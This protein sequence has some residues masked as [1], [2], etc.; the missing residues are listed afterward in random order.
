VI[1]GA[2]L[3]RFLFSSGGV[4]AVIAAVLLSVFLRPRSRLARIS[5]VVVV[6]LYVVASSYPI[7][8]AVAVRLAQPF[9]PLTLEQAPPG[10][11]TAVVLLGSGAYS[12]RS[13]NDT[14]YS[15]LDPIGAERTLEAAR[16]YHLLAP[17]WVISSGG[18]VLDDDPDVPS[19]RLMRDV[20]VTLG[21]PPERIVLEETSRTTRDEATSVRGMLPS[22]GVEHVVLVTSA[23]HMR[24]SVGVFRSV[25]L[26][27]IPAIARDSPHD[28]DGGWLTWLPS[29]DGLDES[30]SVSHEVLGLAYYWLRGWQ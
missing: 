4:I 8:H 19:A 10:A 18:R 1:A 28:P 24:R 22:L 20:L 9:R 15:V 29:D 26:P 25:G 17:R 14:V 12:Q 23:V 6:L 5:L 27:V 30:Q 7:P 2:A 11:K 3:V 13:W 16:L 21:V